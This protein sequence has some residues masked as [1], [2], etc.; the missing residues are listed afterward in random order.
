M[1]TPREA[2]AGA[3]EDLGATATRT[4]GTCLEHGP[5][6]HLRWESDKNTLHQTRV[7]CSCRCA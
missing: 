3:D 4:V 7:T 5:Q 6:A 1:R 2:G